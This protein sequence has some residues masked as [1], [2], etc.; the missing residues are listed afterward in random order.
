MEYIVETNE[1]TKKFPKKVAVQGVSLHIKKGDI[2]GFI[3]KNGAGKTTAMKVILG[4]LKPSSGEVTLFGSRNL[5]EQRKKI[6]SLIEEPG[7]FKN[8]TAYENMKRFAILY[9]ATNE[10]IQRLL[11]EVGLG[12]TGK[13]KVKQFSLGMRQRLGLAIALLG[14][15]ELLVLD[16]PVNGLDPEGI[17]QFRDIILKLN[18]EKGVT[19]LIS[20]HLLDELAKITTVYGIISNGELIE[21]VQADELVERCKMNVKLL[22]DDVQKTVDIIQNSAFACDHQIDGNYVTCFIEAEKSSAINE[23]LVKNGVKVSEL[24]GSSTGFEEYFIKRLG[25]ER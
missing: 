7:L 15:P 16:E 23:L 6:G 12:N 10:D 9:N 25:K 1:L 8:E 22:V 5:N 17:K 19:F 20:S 24:T 14:D 21:E 2:Y 13:R 18:R 11:D 3:G 4:L